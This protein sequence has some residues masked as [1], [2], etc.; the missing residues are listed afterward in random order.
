MP[1]QVWTQDRILER[2]IALQQEG[3]GLSPSRSDIR[4]LVV[5]AVRYFGS[6]RQAVE[7]AG[8]DYDQVLAK[9]QAGRSRKLARWTRE[10]IITRIRQLHLRQED[11][12]SAQVRKT[13]PSL[14]AYARKPEFFGSWEAA[15]Q[16]AGLNPDEVESAS[17]RVRP[18]AGKAWLRLLLL[19]RLK[20]LEQAGQPVA[21]SEEIKKHHPSLYHSAVILFGTW[22]KAATALRKY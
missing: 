1:R 12:A 6:W 13:Y 7:A 11:L 18:P 10:E 4:T 8:L 5:A 20:E 19:E 2:I 22:Q 17:R 15:L 9:S 21:N 16:A 14:H 3:K